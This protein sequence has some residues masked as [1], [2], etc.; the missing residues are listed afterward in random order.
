[1]RDWTRLIGKALKYSYEELVEEGKETVARVLDTIGKYSDPDGA[2]YTLVGLT[3]Y[4][5][6]VDDELSPVEIKLI[7]DVLGI[8]EKEFHGFVKQV[9]NDDKIIKDLTDIVECMNEDELNDFASVLVG[10]FAVD[11]KITDEEMAF[12]KKLCH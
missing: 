9:K 11:G 4:T 6:A 3:A 12:L 7:G 5:A 10:I 2:D 1:M 8:S